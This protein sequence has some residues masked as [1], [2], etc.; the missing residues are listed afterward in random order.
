MRCTINPNTVKKISQ[1]YGSVVK[2]NFL[3]RT[4]LILRKGICH[5]ARWQIYAN[6]FPGSFQLWAI[7]IH[8]MPL[9][10]TASS[11]NSWT[12]GPP[13]YE[14]KFRGEGKYGKL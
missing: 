2:G 12:S 7:L 10:C 13:L 9:E 14:G 1:C 6:S 11:P 8:E 4:Q 5:V 3:R